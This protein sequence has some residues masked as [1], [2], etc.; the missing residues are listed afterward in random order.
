[1]KDWSVVDEL[2]KINVPTLLL[3]GK[4]DAATDEVMQPFFDIIEKVKW[5]RF[6]ESSH[7]PHL[8]ELEEFLKVL[9]GFLTAK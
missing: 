8:E 1:L 4:Y 5:V 3:N 7:M 2:H 9:G 6:A